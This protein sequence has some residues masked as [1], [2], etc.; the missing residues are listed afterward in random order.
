MKLED[1][2]IH[3]TWKAVKPI[4]DYFNQQQLGNKCEIKEAEIDGMREKIQQ[5]QLQLKLKDDL[6]VSLTN[7]GLDKDSYTKGL[8]KL[9]DDINLSE[10]N[11]IKEMQNS[12]NVLMKTLESINYEVLQLKTIINKQLGSKLLKID[13]DVSQLRTFEEQFKNSIQSKSEESSLKNCQLSFSKI[14]NVIREYK[15]RLHNQ[16]TEI[17]KISTNN[18]FLNKQIQSKDQELQE[19]KMKLNDNE[20]VIKSQEEAIQLHEENLFLLKNE[21]KKNDRTTCASFGAS[22]GVHT[23]KIPDFATFDVLCNSDIAGPGWTVIQ[24]RINGRENFSRRWKAYKNGFGRFTGDF[25]LGL[26]KIYRLTNDQPHELYIHMERFDGSTFYA[27]YNDFKIAGEDDKYRL[28]S[29]GQFSGNAEADAMRW[30]ENQQFS[31]L[32]SDNDASKHHDCSNEHRNAGWWY[33]DCA[34]W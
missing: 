6:I 33:S 13:S 10:N 23:V 1:L 5:L 32:D 18:F 30:H 14:Q 7:A 17:T 29:L 20:I 12:N 22:N 15:D 9:K 2:C 25:F 26:E 21:Q 27:H 8:E 3:Y 16:E 31:T 4:L 19:C 24:Q 34:F 11:H 28:L